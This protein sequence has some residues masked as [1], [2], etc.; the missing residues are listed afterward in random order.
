VVAYVKHCHKGFQLDRK[1]KDSGRA[2]EAGAAIV[3]LASDD[4]TARI[5]KRGSSLTSLVAELASGADIILAEGFKSEAV[6]KVEVIAAGD[7]PVC[8]SDHHLIA[9]I[10]DGEHG[11]DVP[12]FGSGDFGP[13]ADFLQEEIVGKESIETDVELEVDGSTVD[14]ND[15]VRSIISSAVY[16]M[17]GN[18]RGVEEPREIRLSIKR[19]KGGDKK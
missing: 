9:A 2:A 8:E 15:F 17:V 5:E 18:L 16:A 4:E 13:F 10:T 19:M 1:D 14:L 11:L 6:R 7:P 3:V 12:V